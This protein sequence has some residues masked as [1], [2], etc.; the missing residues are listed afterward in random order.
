MKIIEVCYPFPIVNR[1]A[2]IFYDSIES[3][4]T[5]AI[6]L[7]RNRR[8]F[9]LRI[10]TEILSDRIAIVARRKVAEFTA[11]KVARLANNGSIEIFADRRTIGELH[12]DRAFD[13]IMINLIETNE[14]S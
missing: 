9:E 8:R 5:D 10:A 14:Q 12:H 1:T 7:Y 2:P 11:E 6:S 4:I 13:K 3:A